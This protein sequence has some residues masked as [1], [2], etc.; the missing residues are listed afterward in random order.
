MLSLR[1]FSQLWGKMGPF[2]IVGM[3]FLAAI[4][5]SRELQ[6]CSVDTTVFTVGTTEDAAT[7]ATALECSSGDFFVQ[8]DGEV[9][10]EETIRLSNATALNITGTAPGATA[11]GRNIAQ[12]FVVDEG[13]RLHLSGTTLAHGSASS[14]GGAIYVESSSVSF[15]GNTVFISNYAGYNGGAISSIRSNVSWDG[16][17]VVFRNNSAGQAGG[18]ITTVDSTLSWNGDGAEF[19]NNYAGQGGAIWVYSS[20]VTWDGDGTEF[21][22]NSAG[23]HGGAI[24]VYNSSVSWYGDGAEFSSNSAGEEGGTMFLMASKVSWDGDDTKFSN[25]SAGGDSGAVL[26]FLSDISWDGDDTEFSNNYA[27]FDGGAIE[28][29]ASNVAWVGDSTEFSNNHAKLGSGGAIFAEDISTVSWNGPTSFI[30]NVAGNGGGA[31]AMVDF[32]DEQTRFTDATF[33][34]N[35]A[36]NG[37]AL[38]L[39]NSAAGFSFTNLSF[40]SNSASGAGGAFA[41]YAGTDHQPATLSR[42]NFSGNTANGAGGAV[43]TLSGQQVFISCNFEGNSAGEEKLFSLSTPFVNGFRVC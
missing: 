14:D 33:I 34:E 2:Q 11:D 13:S 4:A 8:W 26:L 25:N 20:T 9:F 16:D 39:Y 40:Q 23:L 37:G 24:W 21:S 18:A 42:C 28:V 19:S 36:V 22:N 30:S 31:M 7:L 38:Y 10:V 15:S 17:G 43:E 29:I 5:L 35:S 27:G 12:L 41:M 6:D 1:T 3:W 32:G